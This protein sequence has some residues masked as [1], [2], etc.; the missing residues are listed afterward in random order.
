MIE[1]IVI[2]KGTGI[3]PKEHFGLL[4]LR[5]EK[6]GP[7]SRIVN[8]KISAEIGTFGAKSEISVQ[9]QDW[10]AEREGFEPSVRYKRTLAFQASPF[11]HSGISPTICNRLYLLSRSHYRWYRCYLHLEIEPLSDPIG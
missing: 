11:D 2:P 5:N 3:F 7:G 1:A 4:G 10:V 6:F 9:S 8:R